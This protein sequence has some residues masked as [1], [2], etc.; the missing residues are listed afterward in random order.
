MPKAPAWS[1]LAW[2]ICTVWPASPTARMPSCP[3]PPIVVPEITSGWNALDVTPVRSILIPWPPLLVK[4]PPVIDTGERELTPSAAVL[5]TLLLV[6][7]RFCARRV[8]VGVAIEIPVAAY[9]TEE[10]VSW[11]AFEGS[12]TRPPPSPAVVGGGT[13]PGLRTKTQPPPG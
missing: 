10:F 9:R 11:L 7:V 8:P 13:P 2:S 12:R 6:I 3:L 1:M 5:L 4:A